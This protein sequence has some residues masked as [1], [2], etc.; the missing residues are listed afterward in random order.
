MG[1]AKYAVNESVTIDNVQNAAFATVEGGSDL[2]AVNEVVSLTGANNIAV[3]IADDQS[4][5]TMDGQDGLLT[6][7]GENSIGLFRR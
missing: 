7:S 4:V 2:E 1:G 5:F 6:V 3:V